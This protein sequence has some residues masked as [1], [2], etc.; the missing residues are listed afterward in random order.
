VGKAIGVIVL[1]LAIA[2]GVIFGVPSV[3]ARVI[4]VP[5]RMQF[6]QGQENK[7]KMNVEGKV[8]VDVTGLP[9][10]TVPPQVKQFFNTDI[11]FKMEMR[12]RQV[13]KSVTGDVAEIETTMEGGN[14][15]ITLPGSNG[16]PISYP[17]PAGAPT[18]VKMDTHGRVKFDDAAK[19]PAGVNPE[20]MKKVEEFIGNLSGGFLPGETR[21]IGDTWNSQISLPINTEKAKITVSGT[22]NNTF[23][24]VEKK[25]NATVADIAGNQ[26]IK[27]DVT[28]NQEGTEI[29][30][31]GSVTGS[32]H[33][34]FDWSNGQIVATDGNAKID[35]SL[36]V[37]SK[38]LPQDAKAHLT[39]DVKVS[40]EKL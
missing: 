6:K 36:D 24:G 38:Q 26:D 40:L 3:R 16:K 9:D 15:E 21:R 25:A 27:I 29:K 18:T 19:T 2:A 35:L 33:G 5:L 8:K 37:K 20:D 10:N 17:M 1:L 4:G 13:V 22:I 39:G 14:V 28:G 30:L 31:D 12:T 32:N 11:P 7:M 34:Y 23:Q